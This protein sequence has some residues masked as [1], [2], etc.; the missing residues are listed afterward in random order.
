MNVYF[1][2][3]DEQEDQIDCS[4]DIL[5][6]YFKCTWL[7]LF[8]NIWLLAI[9]NKKLSTL[10]YLIAKKHSSFKDN[11]GRNVLHWIALYLD[12]GGI[13]LLFLL[14]ILINSFLF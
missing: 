7:Y 8:D 2:E 5:V 12:G 10:E 14:F 13:S 6:S 9:K 11:D 1:S 4:G 3:E